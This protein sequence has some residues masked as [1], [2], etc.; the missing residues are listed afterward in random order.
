MARTEIVHHV[1]E[2]DP[3]HALPAF[4]TPQGTQ[5]D[6]VVHGHEERDTNLAA[7]GKWFIGLAIGTVATIFLLAGGYKLWDNYQQQVT[8]I[9][10][11]LQKT[12]EPPLPRLIPNPVDDSADRVPIRGPIELN[13]EY[14][15]QMDEA[16]AKIGL[17]DEKSGL[18][19]IPA[20]T[21]QQV[22]Q[23]LRGSG[24]LPA[25]PA[26]APSTDGV[27]FHAPSDSSGGTTTENYH[28]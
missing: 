10:P 20:E 15:Q 23:S 26:N 25:R 21:S 18:A 12:Q 7:I 6:G 16:L 14:Q 4:T 22:I 1:F 8:N 19:S 9:P 13:I 17:H 5:A 3:E 24:T 27:E 11:M 28:R 2:G